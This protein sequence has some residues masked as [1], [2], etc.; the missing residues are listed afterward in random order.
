MIAFINSA[1]LNKRRIK[2][3]KEVMNRK[4]IK[5]DKT[6]KCL[7]CGKD[8]IFVTGRSLYCLFC[9]VDADYTNKRNTRERR[10][11]RQPALSPLVA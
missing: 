2:L 7:L 1:Y 4:K 6:K 9:K 3:L 5:A 11:K 10:K 8:F